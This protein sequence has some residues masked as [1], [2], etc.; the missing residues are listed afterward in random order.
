MSYPL[1][2]AAAFLGLLM[3]QTPARSDDA[4]AHWRLFVAD[5]STPTITALDLHRPDTTW[6]FDVTGP[7]RVHAAPSNDTVVAVQVDDDRVSFIDTG[8][9]I[10]RHGDHGNIDMDE[11]ALIEGGL[12]GR[13]PFHVV[14][15]D[16]VVA[17][18]FDRD[19]H[20]AMV[21]LGDIRDVE[22]GELVAERFTQNRPHHGF[23]MAM[24]DFIVSSVASDEETEDDELPPPVGLAAYDP[25]GAMIGRMATCTDLHGESFSGEYLAAGCKEGVLTLREVDG[26]PEFRLLPY[27]DDFPP[28]EMTGTLLGVKAVQMFLGDHGDDA[29][30][31]IDPERTPHFTRVKLPFRHVDFV[32]DPARP[33]IA[34][35]LTE[36][37]T[38]H[39]LNMQSTE[40]EQST[41]VTRPYSMDGDWND[42]RPRLSVAGDRIV[43]TD[44]LAER[45]RVVDAAELT[46]TDEIPVAGLPYHIVAVGSGGA[47]R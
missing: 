40:I 23:G 42:P 17:T 6:T 37:G 20:V 7:A 24:G 12:S 41:R 26:T 39:R 8:I 38:L 19:G 3:V 47:A 25:D 32:L 45:V 28:D 14:V 31:V 4:T 10:D 11:P 13:Q 9:D 15:H 43:L 18:N 29:L 21:A 16:G 35:V 34:Y 2:G 46:L 5:H 33:E 22:G 27:P 1:R 36:D 44:P 30:V